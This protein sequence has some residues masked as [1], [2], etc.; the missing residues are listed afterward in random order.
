MFA[1]NSETT[2][3]ILMKFFTPRVI[4]SNLKDRLLFNAKSPTQGGAQTGI[5]R[6]TLEMLVYKRFLLVI[7][8]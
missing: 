3:P 7:G 2:G 5:L 6:F 4:F 1:I 8:E